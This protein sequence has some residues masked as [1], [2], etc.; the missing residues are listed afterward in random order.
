MCLIAEFTKPMTLSGKTGSFAGQKQRASA[1]YLSFIWCLLVTEVKFICMYGVDGKKC[2]RSLR[3]T[4]LNN[5]G[6]SV[7]M[8]SWHVLRYREIEQL[9]PLNPPKLSGIQRE[10][11]RPKTK[12]HE[13]FPRAQLLISSSKK[14]HI[15][16]RS[17]DPHSFPW[18]VCRCH[19]VLFLGR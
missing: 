19:S 13:I 18:E 12:D 16:K 3:W 7:C 17:D 14:E 2:V 6:N 8:L 9:Y 10:T 11:N 5:K 4:D 1:A 15:R